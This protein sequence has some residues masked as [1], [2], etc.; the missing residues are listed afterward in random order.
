MKMIEAKSN[1]VLAVLNWLHNKL[2]DYFFIKNS[3]Y[4]M[5]V[6]WFLNARLKCHSYIVVPGG[7]F[8]VG[9]CRRNQHI[10]CCIRSKSSVISMLCSKLIL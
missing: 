8:S 6:S 9:R 5:I 10:L 3:S 7:C 1:Y 2:S 4:I